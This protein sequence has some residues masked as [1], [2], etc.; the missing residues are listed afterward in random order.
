M[1]DFLTTTGT[2]YFIEQLIIT[3]K[4]D[5]V[6]VTP[7]LKLTQN[8]FERISDAEKKGIKITLIYGK[9]ELPKPEMNR[10]LSFKNIQIY[11]CQNLHAKCYHN[12]SAMIITSMNLYEFSE[13]NNR[14]MGIYIEK[15]KDKDIFQQALDEIESIKNNSKLE[16]EF[17]ITINSFQEKESESP[18]KINPKLVLE[19]DPKYNEIGNFHLPSLSKLLKEKYPNKEVLFDRSIIIEKFPF[20]GIKLEVNGRIDFKF[21]ETLNYQL[22]KERNSKLGRE[23]PGIRL[24]WNY[25][26]L[27][28]YTEKDFTVQIND[29]GLKLI[30]EKFLKII[31]HVYENLKLN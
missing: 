4:K 22:I 17:A 25:Y 16:K 18:K 31:D 3:A 12:E 6:L 30:T 11:F 13:R 27:N 1:A 14:E 24:F 20:S 10:L 29:S 8:L 7:F 5:L 26:Q 28:I 9:N 19:L 15:E 23:L 2:S 21:N